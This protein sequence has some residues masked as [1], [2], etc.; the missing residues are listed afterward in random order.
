MTFLSPILMVG[1]V[2]LIA[3]LTK[4]N[5]S[6]ERVISVL[7]ESD[8]FSNDFLSTDNLSYVNFRDIGIE[9]AKDSTTS[10]GYY[11]LL[12][13]PNNADLETVA[14][15]A[16]FYSK[17]S[18]STSILEILEDTF[19]DRLRLG[20]IQDLGVSVSD[21]EAMDKRYEINATTFSG[22]QNLKG[23]NEI[24]AII[25]GG[26]GY[27]IMM[28]IIIYGGFVMRSVIEEKTSRII[29]V[30]I[31]SVKPFQLMLG[32]IIG[33]SLAGITQ[34]AIWIVSGVLLLSVVILIFGIEPAALGNGSTMGPGVVGGITPNSANE[35]LQLYANELFQIPWAMLI[36]FFLIYFILGY[37]IYSSIYAAIGAAVDN[38]TD[39]QQFIF[40]IILPLMLGIYVGFFSVFNNP[41]GP[42]AVAFSLFPLTSPI[43][44]MMRLPGGL[45][46]GGVPIW[47]LITSIALLIV[48]FIGIVWLAAKI[49]RVGILMY[50]K[51]PSYRELFKWLKY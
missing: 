26:F 32:K 41:H 46:A 5:D 15:S 43:V 11:G 35:T 45:G 44:M 49:Y 4:V 12:H 47:Q 22:E 9:A 33:T 23:I 19:Q 37:L 25:G 8:Y 20:R 16:V 7:N 3:Y 17:D 14:Q 18:P 30:I 27:L 28:F 51:K 42:I 39:T 48:T 40:P 36:T 34:F 29:E 21:F 1:M 50:G 38:E 13:I 6:E 31:S 24:K 2:V 10:L